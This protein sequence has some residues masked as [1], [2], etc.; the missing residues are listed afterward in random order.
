MAAGAQQ[1]CRSWVLG[2]LTRALSLVKCVEGEGKLMSEL[3]V[4]LSWSRSASHEVAKVFKDWLPVVLAGTRPWMSSEDIAKG[5]PW[6]VSISAQ[7]AC[8]QACLIFVTPENVESAWLYYEAG[9]IRHAMQDAVICPYLLGVKPSR[10]AATPLSQFQHTIFDKDDTFRLIKTINAKLAS[11]HHEGMLEGN[12]DSKWQILK[13]RVERKMPKWITDDEGEETDLPEKAKTILVEA[14][15]S[16]DGWIFAGRSSD[17]FNMQV[18]NKELCGNFGPR[19][20]AA[21]RSALDHLVAKDLLNQTTEDTFRM[22][23]AG[24]DAADKIGQLSGDVSAA[25]LTDDGDIICLLQSWMGNRTKEQ[26]TSAITFAAVDREL[27]LPAGS[28]SRLLETAAAN[29]H[30]HVQTKGPN[31]VIFQE[32][33]PR[34]SAPMGLSPGITGL[35]G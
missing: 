34:S 12:F 14:G 28:A 6:F 19:A 25:G 23:S 29:V 22:T 16:K 10:L 13:R 8:S 4:F 21:F 32:V 20:E 27:K 18:N 11:P 3:E 15:K 2:G 7:L 26:N 1:L 9:A 33:I 35:R 17:G 30:Y 31:V 24:F 5:T